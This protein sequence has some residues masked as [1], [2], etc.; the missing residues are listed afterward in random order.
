[1]PGSVRTT[2]WESGGSMPHG[3]QS[4]AEVVA[5]NTVLQKRLRFAPSEAEGSE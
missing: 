2:V 4:V 3:R 5:H 1:M